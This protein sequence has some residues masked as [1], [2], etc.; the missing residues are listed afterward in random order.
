MSQWNGIDVRA[1][2]TGISEPLSEQIN[3]LGAM[4]GDA[5]ARLAGP[6]LLD[7]VEEVRGA[8]KEALLQGDDDQPRQRVERRLAELD[9]DQLVWLLRAFGCFFNLANQAESREIVRINRERS[10]A[11]DRP[12]SVRQ[13]WRP[14]LH[15]ASTRPQSGGCWID[16]PSPRR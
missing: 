15:T 9:D 7:L 1:E 8:C 4:L 14:W 5:V 16:S 3:L 10:L 13:Q 11:G 12:E 2:G 6:P